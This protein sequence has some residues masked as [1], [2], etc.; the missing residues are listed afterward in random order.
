MSQFLL[1]TAQ[2]V[3][4]AQLFLKLCEYQAV[5]WDV[6]QLLKLSV[7]IATQLPCV[8]QIIKDSTMLQQLALKLRVELLTHLIKVNGQSLNDC[9]ALKLHLL[10]L[11]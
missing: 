7:K 10:Q 1:Q 3:V 8:F 6:H 5:L 11:V 9:R 4:L 2:Q